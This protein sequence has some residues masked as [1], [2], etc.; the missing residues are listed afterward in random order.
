M[1]VGLVIADGLCVEISCNPYDTS[2]ALGKIELE[3]RTAFRV[4]CSSE[5]LRRPWPV[6]R[7]E[8][9]IVKRF[10]E[11][12]KPVQFHGSTLPITRQAV[13]MNRQPVIAKSR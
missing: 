6:H 10:D 9:G 7:V 3:D 1:I 8:R 11:R 2:G 13:R 5:H 4:K 12:G